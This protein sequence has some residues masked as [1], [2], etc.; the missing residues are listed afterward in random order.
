MNINTLYPIPAAGQ[1]GVTLAV[2]S[3]EVDTTNF[4]STSVSLVWVSVKTDAVYVTFDTSVP[5][6][7]NGIEL[8]AGYQGIWSVAA[9]NAARFIRKTNDASVYATPFA[10]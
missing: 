9:Y 3:T 10:K 4:S 5:A 7:N 2:S 6:A 8:A 1:S